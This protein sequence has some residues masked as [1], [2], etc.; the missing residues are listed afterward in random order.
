MTA[1]PFADVLILTGPTGSG[2]TQLSLELAERLGAE[3]V[4]MDSMTLYRGMDV[5]TAK[6]GPDERWRV[7]HHRIDG[8]W[9]NLPACQRQADGM[10][11]QQNN[12]RP[13]AGALPRT[14]TRR[15]VRPHKLPGRA[16]ERRRVGGRGPGAGPAAAAAQPGDGEGA[17]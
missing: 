1:D 14:A 17:R 12:A 8:V 3:I 5:G 16:D 9:A 7:P 6:P 2:K 10:N 15:T 4:G 11:A 13:A